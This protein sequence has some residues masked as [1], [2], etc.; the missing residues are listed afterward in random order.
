MK[1]IITVIIFLFFSSNLFSQFYTNGYDFHTLPN[2]RV[3]QDI[4]FV[5]SKIGWVVLGN[6][7]STGQPVIYKTTNRGQNWFLVASDFNLFNDGYVIGKVFINFVDENTGWFSFG[8]QYQNSIEYPIYKTTNGGANWQ[9]VFTYVN[10]DSRNGWLKFVNANTGYM[11]NLKGGKI[12][13][14][15]DGG[16]DWNVVY[17]IDNDNN[18][19]IT[20][21]KVSPFNNNIIYASGGK[22]IQYYDGYPILVTTTDG[23]T[24]KH[25]IYDGTSQPGNGIGM[26]SSTDLIIYNNADFVRLASKSGIYKLE[27]TNV[28]LFCSLPSYSF[29]PQIIFK[30]YQEGYKLDGGVIAH[31]TNSGSSW[32]IEF[33]PVIEHG[34]PTRMS[35]FGDAMHFMCAFHDENGGNLETDIATRGIKPHIFTNYDNISSTGNLSLDGSNFNTPFYNYFYGGLYNIVAPFVLNENTENERLFLKWENNNRY[36]VY[37]NARTVDIINDEMT[38]SA[39]YKSKLKSNV[40]SAIGNSPQTKAVRDT[41]WSALPNGIIH[42]IHESMGG[43]FY[44]RSSNGGTT[45][46][47]EEVLTY[48]GTN[49]DIYDGNG[50]KN[51]FLAVKRCG[52]GTYPLTLLDQEKNVAVVWE[53]Y[54]Q[55]T[56]KTEIMISER[57]N[58]IYNT[59]YE[60]SRFVDQANTPVFCSFNSGSN[61]NSFPK[62]FIASPL[63][64][65]LS[66]SVIIVPHLEPTTS[67]NSTKLVITVDYHYSANNQT[68]YYHHDYIVDDGSTGNISNLAVASPFNN[69]NIFGLHI[70]YQK[71]NSINN[72]VYRKINVGRDVFIGPF[73]QEETGEYMANV[74]TGD[75]YSARFWPD[76]S[77]QNGLP[78]ITY[79]GNYYEQRIIS[80]GSEEDNFQTISLQHHPINVKYKKPNGTWSSFLTYDGL[81]QQDN[82][83]IEGS[84]NAAGYLLTFKKN[85]SNYQFVK[86]DGVSGYS[87]SPGVFPG[88]DAKL[89]RGS[90]LGQFGSPFNPM[91]L[92]LS[93]PSNSIYTVGKQLFTITN[94]QS[95]TDGFSNLNGN[96]L[97]NGTSYSLTLGPIIACNAIASTSCGFDDQ[98]PPQIVHNTV[99]FNETMTSNVFSLSNNDTLIL[100][101]NGKYLVEETST[102]TPLIYHVNLVNSNSGNI[103]RE[104][105]KDTISQSD[106][107]GIDFFRGFIITDIE[108]GTDEFYVQMVLDTANTGNADYTMAGVYG[109]NSL[110]A[111]G[112][113]SNAL[114]TKIFFEKQGNS[115]HKINIPNEYSVSQNYPN[116]FNPV[117]NIKYQIPKDGF[118]TLRV[119][120]ITGREIAK[121]VNEVKQA[122]SYTVSF[123]G[124][125]FASGVY[126]YKIQSGDFVKVK[127]MVLVK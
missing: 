127:K 25:T 93:N 87:C 122:G 73:Y 65:N 105:F 31:T 56:Q 23:F 28:I 84:K 75:G 44:S 32:N 6:Y 39:D 77:V 112:D 102:F 40:S 96:V 35:G 21:L 115:N 59:G 33:E 70:A 51:S 121:L 26:I 126:F 125:N 63:N 110:N 109:D 91:L 27:G 107:I 83:N 43:I 1:K 114:K 2:N 29:Q 119:Y 113:N 41:S 60:W 62:L 12:C 53:R 57:V 5:N 74:G 58:N 4:E 15:T 9:N 92:T 71:D 89:I 7:Y 10:D 42:E 80:I 47:K 108:K 38:I 54:N 118:V 11:Y 37:P 3:P 95:Q 117:T 17:Q 79:R 88:E 52:G 106:S 68:Y 78:V 8:Y 85:G 45:F 19:L 30:N 22:S 98:T 55:S 34:G 72:I 100:G 123:N 90:Y 48:F 36:P 20:D 16:M 86:I 67:G 97:L 81:A 18:K 82:P 94:A 120:D 14:T 61:F 116:P 13:K 46:S 104:L 50:N 99:E 111:G 101:A 69:Y 103:L 76:I 124:S 64:G 49:N 66:N 24:S